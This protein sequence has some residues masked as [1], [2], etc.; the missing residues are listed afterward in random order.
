MSSTHNVPCCTRPAQCTWLSR[1]IPH[2]ASLLPVELLLTSKQSVGSNWCTA[3]RHH[4]Q[5]MAAN[6][7]YSH[8]SH[9]VQISEHCVR[10]VLNQFR[11]TIH[12]TATSSLILSLWIH[13]SMPCMLGVYQKHLALCSSLPYL[14][15]T[16]MTLSDELMCRSYLHVMSVK[17][18]SSALTPDV[19]CDTWHLPLPMPWRGLFYNHHSYLVHTSMSFCWNMNAQHYSNPTCRLL[20]LIPKEMR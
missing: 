10:H 18:P 19:T 9:A 14:L 3:L 2:H 13:D 11:S 20:Y 12:C 7:M 15:M 17:Y 4:V 1:T 16:A 8:L 5:E 6:K